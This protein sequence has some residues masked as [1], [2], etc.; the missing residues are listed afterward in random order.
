MSDT[1]KKQKIHAAHCRCRTCSPR[2]PRPAATLAS[3]LAAG[4][5]ILALALALALC[6]ALPALALWPGDTWGSI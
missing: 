1:T 2:A 6:L 5:L 4:I 3:N